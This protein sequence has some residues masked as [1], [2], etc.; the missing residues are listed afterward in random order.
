[1]TRLNVNNDTAELVSRGACRASIVDDSKRC[2]EGSLNSIIVNCNVPLVA[3]YQS[4]AKI[5]HTVLEAIS[6]VPEITSRIINCPVTV[7]ARRG[8]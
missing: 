1:M 2:L 8:V 6:K 5:V 4:A 3:K 7:G